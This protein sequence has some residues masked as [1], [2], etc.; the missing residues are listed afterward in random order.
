[1]ME[2]IGTRKLGGLSHAGQVLAPATRPWI[3][4]LAALCPYD[5]LQTGNIPEF[6]LDPDWNNWV[7]TDSPED[8]LKRINWHVFQQGGTGYLVAP[9]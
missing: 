3:T 7:L 4:D 1:M 6:E 2:Y 5:G 8:P 9:C